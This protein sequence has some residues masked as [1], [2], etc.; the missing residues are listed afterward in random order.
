MTKGPVEAPLSYQSESRDGL[1]SGA[2]VSFPYESQDRQHRSN[3]QKAC[4][5][6][7]FRNR[8]NPTTTTTANRSVSAH[9]T[10]PGKGRFGRERNHGAGV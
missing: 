8:V 6:V 4:R 10:G 3:R 2:P 9:R 7:N 5:C 1:D